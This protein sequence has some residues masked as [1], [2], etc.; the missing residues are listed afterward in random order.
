V[1]E[2][3]VLAALLVG[4]GARALVLGDLDE[5]VQVEWRPRRRRS[6]ATAPPL[7]PDIHANSDGY[8]VIAEAFAAVLGV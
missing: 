1:P 3:Q 6:V 8:G 2:V 5:F 7:G 4:E